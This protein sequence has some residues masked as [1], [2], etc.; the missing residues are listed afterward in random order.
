MDFNQ[1][2]NNLAGLTA[3]NKS[4]ML[5]ILGSLARAVS[6]DRCKVGYADLISYK[7]LNEEDENNGD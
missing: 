7:R 6:G 5:M 4:G 3:G 1:R 2:S